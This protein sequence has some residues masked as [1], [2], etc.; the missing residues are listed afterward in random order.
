MRLRSR[1]S[2]FVHPALYFVFF[3]KKRVSAK[4]SS[5]HSFFARF[6]GRTIC[7]FLALHLWNE[8]LL[9]NMWLSSFFDPYFSMFKKVSIDIPQ[10]VQSM[11]F[12]PHPRR[13]HFCV[14][15]CAIHQDV[16]SQKFRGGLVVLRKVTL[17][18]RSHE[19][20]N[21]TCQY[22]TEIALRRQRQDVP[23]PSTVL[24]GIPRMIARI[25]YP[26][27]FSELFGI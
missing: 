18:G 21:L 12:R 6:R 13:A 11:C 5:D 14:L 25:L 27:S 26:L 15:S 8:P 4:E 3:S 16:I 9:L 20:L 10:S 24:L 22:P 1:Q 17:F 19:T 23:R 2:L 7:S